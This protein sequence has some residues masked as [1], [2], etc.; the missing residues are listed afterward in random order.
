MASNPRDIILSP[1]VTEQSMGAMADGKYTFRVRL[2]ANKSEIKDAVEQIFKV[3]VVGVNTLRNHGKVRRMGKFVGQL[4][5]WK[6][7]IVKLA[8]GQ[9]IKEF[10]GLGG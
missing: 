4:P 6:K 7:A 8:E 3:K 5:D 9:R 2:D 10:E 1:I